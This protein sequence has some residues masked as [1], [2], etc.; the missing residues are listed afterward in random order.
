MNTSQKKKAYLKAPYKCPHCGYE[1]VT[2][3]EQVQLDGMV[4][5]QEVACNKCCASWTDIYKLVDVKFTT[6]P[7][8]KTT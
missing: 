4:G 1:D 7:E 5:T 6:K 3:N 8:R 2:A